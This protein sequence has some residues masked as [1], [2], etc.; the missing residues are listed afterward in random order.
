VARYKP[1]H[2]AP[3]KGKRPASGAGKAAG[4]WD[5]APDGTVT[6]DAAVASGL[7]R[8]G[9]Q[10][11]RRRLIVRALGLVVLAAIGVSVGGVIG[12]QDRASTG[13]AVTGAEIEPN[14]TTPA[15]VVSGQPGQASQVSARVVAENAH[16]GSTGWKLT[17]P[18]DNHEIEG[19]A[20]H[21]S[22]TSGQ[23]VTLFVST[24]APTF[25]V[26][27]Y[28][29]GYYQGL[30]GRLVQDSPETAGVHQ[31]APVFTPR[32]NMVEAPWQPS[33]VLSTT[34]W[35]EG[36]YLLKLVASTGQQRYVP[37]T[38]RNDASTAT[39]VIINAITTWQAYNLWGGYDLYEGQNRGLSDYAHRSRTVSFDR[40]Y[41]LGEGAGDFLGLEYPLVSLVESLG[42]D[43]TYLT[44]IDLQHPS[45][46]LLGHKAV[47]S[48]GHDEYYSLVM[49]QNLQQARDRGVNLAF[50]GA[51]AIFRHIRLAPSPLGTD[52]HEIDY[53]SAREDP[54]FGKDNAD[55][56]VDWRD[57]PNNNPESQIIGDFYQCNPVRADM[58]V[59][60]PNNWLF[61]GTGATAGQKLANV[62]GSEYDRY[63]PTVA[64]P[65]NVEILT[66]SP[67]RCGGHNDFADATYYSAPSGAGVF[68]AGTIDWVGNMDTHC[69]PDGCPGQVLGKVTEN[70]L[71][72]FATGPAGLEHPSVPGQSTVP[73]KAPVTSK[74]PT[75]TTGGGST[76]SALAPKSGGEQE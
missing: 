59:V 64:G 28:R 38:V 65:A 41:T 73:T 47:I 18:A 20:D 39:F 32:I 30:G 49:R 13:A 24:A 3:R 75:S 44:D 7:A 71:A 69:Q 53:K 22:I 11:Q 23:P 70:L 51:N 16:A 26:E 14:V 72:A 37:L 9:G 34:T 45:N 6:P 19:Y 48:P 15:T 25:H 40:P 67:L 1:A 36:D 62:V 12:Q 57:A 60:D 8:A 35:P 58:V 5:G 74:G 55:V 46:P 50:L 27:A 2:A 54:L 10:L 61:A 29:M 4:R 42:I 31:A 56:T 52:R 63:D 43:V 68:A 66:H 76:G 33:L 17:V 21:T